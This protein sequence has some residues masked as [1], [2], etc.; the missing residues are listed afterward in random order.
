MRTKTFVE[1]GV[2]HYSILQYTKLD[3]VLMLNTYVQQYNIE[4]KE[5]VSHYNIDSFTDELMLKYVSFQR[6]LLQSEAM[7]YNDHFKT[8]KY[9]GWIK[10][11]HPQ[12]KLGKI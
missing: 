12:F 7:Y 6:Y 8:K 11:N 1:N 5:N 2:T 4:T 3:A 10:D 9:I